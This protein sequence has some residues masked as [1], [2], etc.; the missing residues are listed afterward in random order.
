ML[1][2]GVTI[3]KIQGDDPLLQDLVLPRGDCRPMGFVK[4]VATRL[5]EDQ[6]NLHPISGDATSK[7]FLVRLHE[8]KHGLPSVNQVDGH[9][10][11]PP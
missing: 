11:S 8:L 3:E 2:P 9:T 4:L 10:P 6:M 7:A 1:H 5:V